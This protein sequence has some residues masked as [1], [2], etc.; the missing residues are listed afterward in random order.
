MLAKPRLQVGV[1]AVAPGDVL[2]EQAVL[3][4]WAL[5][6]AAQFDPHALVVLHT[7]WQVAPV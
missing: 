2:P 3:E 5:E 6:H 7:V 4:A 1:H